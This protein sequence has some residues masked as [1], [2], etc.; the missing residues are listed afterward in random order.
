MAKVNLEKKTAEQKNAELIAHLDAEE[1]AENEL[2]E[3]YQE[4]E[5]LHKYYPAKVSELQKRIKEAEQKTT[6]LR[7]ERKNKK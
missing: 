4:L 1:S 5:K 6:D 7:L 3:L 2:V